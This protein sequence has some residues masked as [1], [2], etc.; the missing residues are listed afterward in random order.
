MI[1]NNAWN[2]GGKVTFIALITSVLVTWPG[3]SH[4]KSLLYCHTL[5]HTSTDH[6]SSIKAS[7]E[8]IASR[9]R[10]TA[11]LCATA[12][13]NWFESI[14][15]SESNSHRVW[16]VWPF[17]KVYRHFGPRT[18]RTQ[19]TSD[20]GHFGPRTLRHQCRSVLKTLRHWCRNV[21]VSLGH[22]GTSS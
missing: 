13:N 12:V 6:A 15:Q 19:D 16:F 3:I 4:Y 18:L 2:D 11:Q 21:R 20:L 7:K 17:A 5:T 9:G 1:F 10:G 22:F 8:A 14:Q